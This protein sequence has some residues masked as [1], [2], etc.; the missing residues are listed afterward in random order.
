MQI[1][2]STGGRAGGGVGGGGSVALGGAPAQ[3]ARTGAEGAFSAAR[4]GGG[5]GGGAQ[6]A[7]SRSSATHH[8]QSTAA[9]ARAARPTRPGASSR[10]KYA[11]RGAVQCALALA[12]AGGREAAQTAARTRGH[13]ATA[14]PLPTAHDR[15]RTLF[16]ERRSAPRCPP[17]ARCQ[18]YAK[19]RAGGDAICTAVSR[20]DDQA[21]AVDV[22]LG[23]DSLFIEKHRIPR[24]PEDRKARVFETPVDLNMDIFYQEILRKA[25]PIPSPEVSAATYPRQHYTLS[26]SLG[27]V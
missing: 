26:Q 11:H 25:G 8:H 20:I 2:D 6:S 15:A 16:R 24:M 23:R 19:L 10:P 1:G 4:T 22:L 5:P 12:P 18:F 17:A 9:S 3:A 27:S 14:A 13:T 7:T 21:A